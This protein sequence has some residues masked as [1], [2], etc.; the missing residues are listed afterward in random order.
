MVENVLKVIGSQSDLHTFHNEKWA[1]HTFH[2]KLV[3]PKPKDRKNI[4]LSFDDKWVTLGHLYVEKHQEFY[5]YLFETDDFPPHS[6]IKSLANEY[7][8]LKFELCYG[9]ND[10]D[11]TKSYSCRIIYENGLQVSHVGGDYE[12][13][14]DEFR[15]DIAKYAIKFEDHIEYYYERKT[16]LLEENEKYNK[17][18][19]KLETIQDY[20]E[21]EENITFKTIVDTVF[22]YEKKIYD[23]AEELREVEELLNNYEARIQLQEVCKILTSDKRLHYWYQNRYNLA[24][25]VAMKGVFGEPP[26]DIDAWNEKRNWKKISDKPVTVLEIKMKQISMNISFNKLAK[27]VKNHIYHPDHTFVKQS[28]QS[29]TRDSANPLR[30]PRR[31]RTRRNSYTRSI[32]PIARFVAISWLRMHPHFES[33]KKQKK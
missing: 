32:L 12:E 11:Y 27:S 29:H 6:F 17:K 31:T 16:V 10:D 13:F 25:Y 7:R 9:E 18:I 20:L 21:Y 1:Q 2:E 19:S 4:K 28:L 24:D 14:Q 26:F 15:G 30:A 22:N 8:N 5:E 3:Q 33:C 23:N